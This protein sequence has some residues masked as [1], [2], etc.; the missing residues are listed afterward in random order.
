[1]LV[2]ELSQ[3]ASLRNGDL[4][5][6]HQ[7]IHESQLGPVVPGTFG[8]AD[9]LAAVEAGVPAILF[10]NPEWVQRVSTGFPEF[11]GMRWKVRRTMSRDV[12]L[13]PLLIS[14]FPALKSIPFA[15]PVY[16]AITDGP[17]IH[18]REGKRRSQKIQAASI[19]TNKVGDVF[20]Q[21]VRVGTGTIWAIPPTKDNAA[22]TVAA[23]DQKELLTMQT[24]APTSHETYWK[25]LHPVISKVAKSRFDSGHYADAVEAAL[26][27]VNDVVRG[28]VKTKTG[29]EL[30]GAELMNF[31]LSLKKPV[32]ELDDLSTT[33]G[34]SIQVGYM[35]IFAGAMTGVRNPKAHAN[36]TIT[37]ERAVHLLV[38]ASLLLYKI[39]ERAK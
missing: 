28:I 24:P 20:A 30:D 27:E 39:D 35:Q 17:D 31:A 3:T 18:V 9:V 36:I 1:M 26:K 11:F 15:R 25:I 14:A 19:V 21:S 6:D 23:I 38:L 16:Y 4:V 22:F 29:Q 5:F 32:I 10:L 13:H 7:V 33:S 12:T 8:P 37:P 34:K 2:P